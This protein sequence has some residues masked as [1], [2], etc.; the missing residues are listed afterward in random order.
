V[1][2]PLVVTYKDFIR[3][4]DLPGDSPIGVVRQ[5]MLEFVDA[6]GTVLTVRDI[7]TER[8]RKVTLTIAPSQ[9]G[10]GTPPRRGT[11]KDVRKGWTMT[12]GKRGD[13][14]NRSEGDI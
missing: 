8:R 6:H 5:R 7:P 11:G 10:Q 2:R 1:P 13:F 9:Q 14:T 3:V 12:G 4:L